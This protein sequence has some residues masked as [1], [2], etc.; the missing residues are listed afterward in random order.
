[1]KVGELRFGARIR[2]RFEGGQ[3][4][5]LDVECDRVGRLKP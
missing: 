2:T 4:G 5:V 3:D 1:M